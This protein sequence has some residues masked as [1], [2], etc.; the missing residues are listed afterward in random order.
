MRQPLYEVVTL[1]NGVKFGTRNP[2]RTKGEF[3]LNRFKSAWQNA[4]LKAGLCGE[5]Q[6]RICRCAMHVNKA[7]FQ[8]DRWQARANGPFIVWQHVVT[9]LDTIDR[10]KR[11]NDNATRIHRRIN[12]VC[13]CVCFS[14]LFFTILNKAIYVYTGALSLQFRRV[15]VDNLDFHL[16][17]CALKWCS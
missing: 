4:A 13:L 5:S 14:V 16:M 2:S 12:V 17:F 8:S 15:A 7:H 10:Y 6:Q 3:A 9:P 1:L 11:P